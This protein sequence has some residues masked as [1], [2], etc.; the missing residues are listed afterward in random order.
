MSKDTMLTMARQD[1][2]VI[3][4][5]LQHL[6]DDEVELNAIGFH[7]EQLL[8][9]TMKYVLEINGIKCAHI[10]GISDL[11]DCN[12]NL[13]SNMSL[14]LRAYFGILDSWSYITKCVKGYRTNLET[15]KEVLPIVQE[16]AQLV[17]NKCTSEFK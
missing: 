15:I 13:F 12:E 16:Y 6:T 4:T 9:K 10:Y 17:K 14:E 7:I 3:T 1:E 11:Y 2:F 8:E 5:C